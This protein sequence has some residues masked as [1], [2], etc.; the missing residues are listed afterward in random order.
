[1]P[2]CPSCS[3][4]V[5]EDIAYCGHCGAAI[6]TPEISIST[7]QPQLSSQGAP[8][9]PNTCVNGDMSGRLEKAMRR[10]ELLG[11]AAAGLGA[12]ILVVLIV[13]SLL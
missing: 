11:Y 12:A 10:A 6:N 5:P 13:I 1:M 8:D 9:W 4:L 7:S 2:T 3:A